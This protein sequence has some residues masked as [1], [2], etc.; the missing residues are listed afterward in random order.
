MAVQITLLLLVCIAAAY[1]L[2]YRR[3]PNW[4]VVSGLMS[5]AVLQFTLHGRRGLQES[6]LGFGLALLI[7]VP[8]YL[9]RAMGGGDL[10]LMAAVGAL[11][12]PEHWFSLFLVTA[13]LGGV[14]AILLLIWTGRVRTGLRNVGRILASLARGHAPYRQ[15]PEIDIASPSAATLPHG[16]VIAAGAIC[17]LLVLA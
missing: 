11:M 1:D 3:I 6:A 16:A 12:G 10:K 15:H 2:R 7:Y 9:L 4:L 17:Y 14:L 5:A 13:I 8:L